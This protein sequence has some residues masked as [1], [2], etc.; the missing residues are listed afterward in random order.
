MRV[1]PRTRLKMHSGNDLHRWTV[2]FADFMTL[3]FA[4]FVLLYA[5]SI[6]QEEQYKE[7]IVKIQKASKL[8]NQSVFS[9]EREGILTENSNSIIEDS[10]PA[11]RSEGMIN[12]AN[13]EL[14]DVDTLK[15]GWELKQLKTELEVLLSSEIDEEV[16]KLDLDGD[17]LTIEMGGDLLF[18]GGSHT[19]LIAAKK[20]LNKISE[21]LKPI[22]NLLRIRGYTDNNLIAD[23]IYQSNWEL[24]G[25]RAFSVLHALNSHGIDGRRMVVEAYGRYTLAKDAQ[26]KIDKLGSRRV[27]IAISKY[28]LVEPVAIIKAKVEK[29]EPIKAKVKDS[30]NIQEIYLPNE[31]LIITT[32][33]D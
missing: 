8:L 29:K 24:S 7:V 12:Q 1:R 25:A 13:D 17:W 6:N 23:E 10:G 11:I 28:A 9:S 2:S 27:V 33:M 21:A 5:V 14:S 19:L 32:R 16:L 20:R 3:M 15:A 26:G 4:V 22:N 30:E 31:R 18:A